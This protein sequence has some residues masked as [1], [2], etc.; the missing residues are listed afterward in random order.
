MGYA[1]QPVQRMRC[2]TEH[3]QAN[4]GGK[5]SHDFKLH[6]KT[7]LPEIL[8]ISCRRKWPAEKKV[9]IQMLIEDNSKPHDIVICTSGVVT[10]YQ[11]G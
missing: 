10:C 6:T 5:C 9:E 3:K 7:L 8:G 4:D 11:S 2:L 1:E